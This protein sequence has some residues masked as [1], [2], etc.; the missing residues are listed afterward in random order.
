MELGL[1]VQKDYAAAWMLRL[2]KQ[3]QDLAGRTDLVR[4]RTMVMDQQRDRD[5]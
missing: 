4:R 1:V 2:R 5:G 3:Q